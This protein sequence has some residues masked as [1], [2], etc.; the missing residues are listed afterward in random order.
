MTAPSLS[1]VLPTWQGRADLERLLPR[2]LEQ[3]LW[4][5]TELVAIDSGSTDGSIDVLE[6]AGARV[7]SI[8][9]REFRHGGTRNRAAAWAHGEILVFLSQDTVPVGVGFLERLVEPFEDERV[10]GVCARVLP[11]PDSDLLTSRTV[12]DLPEASSEPEVRELG[13]HDGLWEFDAEQRARLLRFNNV[14]S[15]I[16]ADV[17]RRIP[18]PDVAFGEDFA[19]AA[20]ALTAGWKL[21]YHPQ[22]AVE[23]AHRYGPLSAY[24][25]YRTDALFHAESHG[26]KL[27]PSLW[28]A[29]RGIGFELRADWACARSRGLARHARDLAR[30]P[31]LRGAQVLGQYVGSRG[32]RPSRQRRELP[33]P[34]G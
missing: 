32:S 25:R 23:H 2:L 26:W 29:L 18:F 16:R 14:A 12:L 6:S 1:V 17:L 15:A 28:S 21:V 33:F 5:G 13:D 31:L 19:W 9:Q 10:A 4:P 34:I 3:T 22:A 24:R 11:H 7:E 27:R 20:R 30:A 8:D